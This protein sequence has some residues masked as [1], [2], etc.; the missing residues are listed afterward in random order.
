MKKI[1]LVC[2]YIGSVVA[3]DLGRSLPSAHACKLVARGEIMTKGVVPLETLSV[4]ELLFEKT[5]DELESRQIQGASQH[6][7]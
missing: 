3:A 2:G 5:I 7:P 1:I 4:E 6:Q